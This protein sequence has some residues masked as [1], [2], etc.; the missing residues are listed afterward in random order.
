MYPGGLA[1]NSGAVHLY[2][3]AIVHFGLDRVKVFLN[4]ISVTGRDKAMPLGVF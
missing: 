1:Y 4:E 3:D 2:N